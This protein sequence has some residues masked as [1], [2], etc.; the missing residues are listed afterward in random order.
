[1]PTPRADCQAGF[2]TYP[3]GTNGVLVAGGN[4]ERRAEFL[5]LETLVWVPK[6]DLPVDIH[7]GA[8]VPYQDSFLIVGGIKVSSTYLDSVYYYNPNS[9]IWELIYTLDYG[10]AYS[11]A[12]LVPDSFAYCN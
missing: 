1:M 5:N 4:Y 6:A 12:F 2:V 11:G 9:D 7:L 10:T 8:S 3:D